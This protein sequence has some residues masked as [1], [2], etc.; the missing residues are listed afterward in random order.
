MFDYEYI[1]ISRKSLCFIRECVRAVWFIMEFSLKRAGPP[2]S[3]FPFGPG[4]FPF[5]FCGA[6]CVLVSPMISREFQ[7]FL[8]SSVKSGDFR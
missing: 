3:Q 8:M 7:C 6:Q 4:A 5:P 1:M 2:F